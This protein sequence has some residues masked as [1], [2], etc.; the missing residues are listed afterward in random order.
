LRRIFDRK[1]GRL[2]ANGTYRWDLL[3]NYGATER[4][5]FR[6][7]EVP[8]FLDFQ[9]ALRDASW[10]E[11]R[12]FCERRDGVTTTNPF[13]PAINR[14]ERF[15]DRPAYDR[16]KKF[17]RPPLLE[18][19]QQPGPA[20]KTFGQRKISLQF[21]TMAKR[22][23]FAK[24]KRKPRGIYLLLLFFVLQNVGKCKAKNSASIWRIILRRD[25]P[26]FS[27]YRFAAEVDATARLSVGDGPV[28]LPGDARG[29]PAR[30]GAA[31]SSSAEAGILRP[32][33][34]VGVPCQL[35]LHAR[36]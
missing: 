19:E 33:A 13:L 36:H 30:Q 26:E 3:S 12:I 17:S 23:Q 10:R 32:T 31:G 20:R 1:E 6:P 15:R 24:L 2:D 28:R 25:S 18:G 21:P 9:R 35:S 4:P 34:K 8:H 14:T 16:E 7:I 27:P 5:I 29:H 22:K 11:R